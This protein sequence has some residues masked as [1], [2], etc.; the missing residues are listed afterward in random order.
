MIGHV[1]SLA[2]LDIY[3]VHR[4]G[5]THHSNHANFGA[6]SVLV[7]CAISTRPVGKRKRAARTGARL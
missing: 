6:A 5:H 7:D 4:I 1:D 2:G 3:T